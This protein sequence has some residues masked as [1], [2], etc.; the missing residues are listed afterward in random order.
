MV[1]GTES[2][3]DAAKGKSRKKKPPKL[4]NSRVIADPVSAE[5]ALA[6]GEMTEGVEVTIG[7]LTEAQAKD[8]DNAGK[9]LVSV[10]YGRGTGSVRRGRSTA[11]WANLTVINVA[12]GPLPRKPRPTQ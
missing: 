10:D 7:N 8:P 1:R 4:E 5:R 2:E 9:V 11:F 12:Q 6:A 3:E